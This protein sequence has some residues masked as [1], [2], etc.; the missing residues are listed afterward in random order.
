ML[1][2]EGE[3]RGGRGERERLNREEEEERER[4]NREEED[5]RGGGKERLNREE[6]EEA[7]VLL[8]VPCL[9]VCGGCVTGVQC[10]VKLGLKEEGGVGVRSGS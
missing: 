4:P 5:K 2:E 1:V 9:K 7:S 6:E 10:L 3:Q 8:T